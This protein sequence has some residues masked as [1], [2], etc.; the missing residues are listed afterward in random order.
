MSPPHLGISHNTLV[1]SYPDWPSLQRIAIN[2]PDPFLIL[3]ISIPTI[4]NT[5]NDA[6]WLVP[7]QMRIQVKKLRSGGGSNMSLEVSS[8]VTHVGTRR[9]NVLLQ[10][11]QE[12]TVSGSLTD[13]TSHYLGKV[14]VACDLVSDEAGLNELLPKSLLPT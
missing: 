3:S 6:I 14:D 10:P 11:G 9:E 2:T 7:E 1:V 13:V 8:P 4:K 12:V 5:G